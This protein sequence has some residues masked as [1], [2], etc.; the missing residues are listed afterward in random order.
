MPNHG[1]NGRRR[2]GAYG[3]GYGGPRSNALP[4]RAQRKPGR[5]PQRFKKCSID[6]ERD[7]GTKGSR[8]RARGSAKHDGAG[9]RLL[10]ARSKGAVRRP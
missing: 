2:S 10:A 4:P 8:N 1:T 9:R 6:R 3:V 5:A 7:P